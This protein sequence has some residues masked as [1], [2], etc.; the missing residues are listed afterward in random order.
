MN[1]IRLNIGASFAFPVLLDA[2]IISTV[3][4]MVRCRLISPSH[5]YQIQLTIFKANFYSSW[6]TRS[7]F[8]LLPFDIVFSRYNAKVKRKI[9]IRARLSHSQCV[10]AFILYARFLLLLHYF[11]VVAFVVVG[12]CC[13]CF[14][15]FCRFLRWFRRNWTSFTVAS[16][17]TFNKKP[18]PYFC[19]TFFVWIPN[20]IILFSS[21]VRF[22]C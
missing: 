20:T 2:L 21:F 19:G 9:R 7:A 18:I 1:E 15:S 12:A 13:C 3:T 14:F 16:L 5:R 11:F 17:S 22:G 4:L 10:C 8:A 6:R